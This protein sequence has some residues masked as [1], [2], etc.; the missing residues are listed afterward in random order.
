MEKHT[1]NL[2]EKKYNS[3]IMLEDD[4]DTGGDSNVGECDR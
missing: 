3:V 1:N 4:K 2:W